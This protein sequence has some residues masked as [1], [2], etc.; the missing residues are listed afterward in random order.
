MPDHLRKG[1]GEVD[2]YPLAQL[3]TFEAP[4]GASILESI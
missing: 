1:G 4:V 2:Q 3:V